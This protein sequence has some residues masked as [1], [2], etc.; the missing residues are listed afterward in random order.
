ML[1]LFFHRVVHVQLALG[2]ACRARLV[3]GIPVCD[4]GLEAAHRLEHLVD[5]FLQLLAQGLDRGAVSLAVRE[6]ALPTNGC[7][8]IAQR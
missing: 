1:P 3:G 2:V 5:L 8:A 4:L 7:T 6:R